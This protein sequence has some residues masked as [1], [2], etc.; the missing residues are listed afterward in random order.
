MRSDVPKVLHRMCGKPML[1]WVV[2]AAREAGRAPHRLRRP[3]GRR[4]G[5]GPA[6]GRGARRAAPTARAPGP[7][8]SPPA[9]TS[10]RGR[11][12]GDPLGRPSACLG[13]APRPASWAP[14]RD[15][16]A[17]ATLLTTEILDP[18][19]YGRIVRDGDGTVTR[20]VETKHPDGVPADE[21]AIREINL[22]TYVFDPVALL[23]RPRR[24]GR[25]E[26]RA[27]PDG[28]VPG[29]PRPRASTSP[30]T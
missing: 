7:P 1:D 15:E 23:V 5:R 6:G 17:T 4:R 13:R 19:G 12:R 2:D 28:R 20:I 9:I 25:P 11:C 8:C 29:H 22:G 18:A 30:P 26:R 3:P 14:T 21:L 16:G 10:S 24:G 27:L